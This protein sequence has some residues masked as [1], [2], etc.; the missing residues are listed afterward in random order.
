MSQNIFST[1]NPATT[2]GT[3][4][5]TLLN[6][7]KEA[8]VSGM[9]GTARPSE[10]DAYGMWV[11]T[12]DEGSDLIYLKM[13]DGTTDILMMTLNLATGAFSFPG[14]EDQFEI[15][16]TSDDTVGAILKFVK[17]R[18]TAP[19]QTLD[20]DIVGSLDF[21]GTT[22]ASAETK[23][24]EMYV[25]V[26]DNVTASAKGSRFIWRAVVDATATVT[27][28]MRLVDKKLGVGVTTVLESIHAIGNI[29]GEN[30]EDSTSPAKLV[31]RKKR[32]TGVGQVLSGDSIAS[33]SLKSVDVA[34]TEFE[35]ADL[36]CEATENQTASARGNKIT[37]AT[38]DVG[39]ASK[40]NKV[41]IAEEIE[42]L[43]NTKVTTLESSDYHYF[44]DPT[45]DGSWRHGL[46][47]GQYVIEKRES[48]VWI[49]KQTL[50]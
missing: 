18:A 31:L 6:N 17:A 36:L 27:E 3:A 50:S 34:G 8:M 24:A 16:K 13:Y 45:V 35:G 48:G 49:N 28:F 32:V 10:L 4:L 40:S 44:G 5:A 19:G 15:S 42:N 9:S 47:G 41:I 7:F 20:G 38:T 29:R 37:I 12:V 30:T 14:S 39:S 11:D 46:T 1:I 22:D 26:S 2:S 23:V 33:I 21:Y 43:V 25:E